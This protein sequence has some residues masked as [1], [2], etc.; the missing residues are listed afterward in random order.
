M[1]REWDVR[2]KEGSDKKPPTFW[3][4]I[5]IESLLLLLLL[6]LALNR[7]WWWSVIMTAAKHQSP[8][9]GRALN[10]VDRICLL[11]FVFDALTHLSLGVCEF[12][13]A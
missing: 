6:L 13:I 9:H 4:N 7:C 2:G 8:L 3:V 11:W 12:A 1:Q 10:F 5:G